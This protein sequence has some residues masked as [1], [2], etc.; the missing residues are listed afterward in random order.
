MSVPSTVALYFFLLDKSDFDRLRAFDDVI[1]RQDVSLLVDDEAGALAL[2]GH[3]LVEEVVSNLHRRD[4]HHRRQRALVD[5]D[6]LL[7][8]GVERR[9]RF[10][11]GQLEGSQRTVHRR[12]RYAGRPCCCAVHQTGD[13]P[14]G[15]EVS[16]QQIETTEDQQNK[17]HRTQLHG[18]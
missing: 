14:D 17:Q 7:L 12:R 13:R 18:R 5:R 10:G 3:R 9:C 6:V 2:F 15:K 4:V 11:L 16:G 8:F 1:V